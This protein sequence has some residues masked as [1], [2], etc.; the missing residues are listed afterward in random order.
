[1]PVLRAY[2]SVDADRALATARR[3]DDA[4]RN[5]GSGALPPFL[6]VPISIKDVIDA[7]GL[8]TTHSS[9]VLADHVATEDDPLVERLRHARFI[10]L[11]KST[12]PEFCTSMTSSELNGICRTPWDTARTPGGSSGGAAAGRPAGLWAGG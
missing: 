1:D 12:V 11:G 2:V 7:E 9:K 5:N 10:V 3:A 8:P 6:G 4:V